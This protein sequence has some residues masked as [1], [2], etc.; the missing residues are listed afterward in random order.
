MCCELKLLHCII[1]LYCV[2]QCT[3]NIF[4]S[5][6]PRPPR[7]RRFKPTTSHKGR[8]YPVLLSLQVSNGRQYTFGVK[9]S[10]RLQWNMANKGRSLCC[11]MNRL[12]GLPNPVNEEKVFLK[13][14]GQMLGK[15]SWSFSSW[16]TLGRTNILQPHK[17]REE[18]SRNKTKSMYISKFLYVTCIPI[19]SCH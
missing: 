9:F 19:Y 11:F 3:S 10:G 4:N 17:G 6:F 8:T 14:C 16:L 2:V 1:S 12:S 5:R 7:V 18:N 13:K 15:R